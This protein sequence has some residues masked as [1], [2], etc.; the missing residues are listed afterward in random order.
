MY[1]TDN[2]SASYYQTAYDN[3]GYGGMAYYTL[4]TCGYVNGHY[5]ATGCM[6]SYESSDIKYV[7]DGWKNMILVMDVVI[8]KIE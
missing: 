4:E 5:I 1:I 6:I 7:V 8:N 3:A 2:T